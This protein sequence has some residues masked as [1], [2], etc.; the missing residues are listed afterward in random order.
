MRSANASASAAV[1]PSRPAQTPSLP[2]IMV[3]VLPRCCLPPR[4]DVTG[5]CPGASADAVRV[6]P[7]SGGPARPAPAAHSE[8][9]DDRDVA[10]I[11]RNA[12]HEGRPVRTDLIVNVTREPA[13]ERHAANVAEEPKW[14]APSS[15]GGGEQLAQHE[16]VGGNDA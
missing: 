16:D 15:L 10:D 6:R 2:S 3:H 7:V 11:E 4:D 1:M 14:N 12:E 5:L 8:P 9:P 13:T